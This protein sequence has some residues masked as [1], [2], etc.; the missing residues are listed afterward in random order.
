[1]N[2]NKDD[3]VEDRKLGVEPICRVLH[4]TP[5]TYYAA[6]GC[7]PSVRALNDV[8]LSPQLSD[9]WENNLQVYGVRKLWKVA[10]RAGTYIGRDQTARLIKT[11][12]SAV[13]CG[14]I[15]RKRP[16]QTR[17]QRGIRT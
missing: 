6:R 16:N 14:R 2:A 8:M 4:V 15:R 13:L 11:L 17:Q 1:V 5:S 9:L 10:R 7:V 3:V 12:E